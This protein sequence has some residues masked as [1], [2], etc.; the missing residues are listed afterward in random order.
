MENMAHKEIGEEIKMIQKAYQKLDDGLMYLANKAVKGYNW[1]TGRTKADLANECITCAAIL[2]PTGSFM[3]SN[4][5][6]GIIS[7]PIIL[8]AHYEQLDNK[9]IEALENIAN[10]R[11]CLDPK[12]E[13]YKQRCSFWGPTQ[14]FF[15]GT[16]V[17]T[18]VNSL[19]LNIALFNSAASNYVMRAD[20]LPPRKNCFARGWDELKKH[21]A[22]RKLQPAYVTNSRLPLEGM[23]DSLEVAK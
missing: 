13:S 1:T 18:N 22:E 10:E 14:L 11:R 5:F 17:P 7:A 19:I 3:F 23:L 6:G 2:F 20:N 15:S 8:S 16:V 12:V 21:L 4:L 9:K